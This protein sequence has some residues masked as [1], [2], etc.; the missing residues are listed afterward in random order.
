MSLAKA[1]DDIGLPAANREKWR[2]LAERT[3]ANASLESLQS[4]ADG[5][6][7]ESD[8]DV[9]FVAGRVSER[10]WVVVQRIDDR[11]PR[12]A[13]RQAHED[14]AR[15]ATGLSLIFDGAPNA[16]GFG[17]PV[18]AETLDAVLAGIRLNQTYLRLDVNPASR[19]LA[20]WFVAYLSKRRVDPAKLSLSFGIDPAAIFASTGRLPM[21]IEALQASMPQSLAHFFAL[22]VPGVLLEA[23][24]R[25][26]HNAGA[27]EAQELGAVLAS[28]AAHLRLFEDARQALVYA[29]PHIGFVVSVD[30]DQSLSTAKIR[31]L[32]KSWARMLE[33]RSIPPSPT[34]IHAETSWRMMTAAD[35]ETNILRSMVACS[36]AASG[37]ADSVSVLPHTM[38]RGLPDAFARR[39]ARTTQLIVASEEDTDRGGYPVAGFSEIGAL[40]DALCERAWEAFQTIES[41]GGI[42]RSLAAGRLQRRIA[43]ARSRLLH[44]HR[45][46]KREIAGT[47][48]YPQAAGKQAETSAATRHDPAT[49]SAVF[50]KRLD[51]RR[52][53]ELLGSDT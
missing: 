9:S 23:D 19:A 2:T 50:C 49:D 36:A 27:T 4:P 7:S 11:D 38:T 30:Q 31:A 10:P 8:D 48:A 47:A 34:A 45:E 41:E 18:E 35:P 52:L 51:G 28:A 6:R 15:G 5:I 1:L 46:G 42:L 33:A 26:Y 39:V 24:G 44:Q 21:A 13:N 17:L 32:R 37:G 20:D 16:F 40:A 14:L 25:V 3:L 53:D 43:A 22:G 12:R 29:A